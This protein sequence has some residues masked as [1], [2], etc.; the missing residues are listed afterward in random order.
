MKIGI[1]LLAVILA[2]VLIGTVAAT[3]LQQVY[4]PRECPGCG[5]EF[6]DN[7][8]LDDRNSTTNVLRHNQSESSTLNLT[9]IDGSTLGKQ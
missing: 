4:A 9:N 8:T 6:N 5:F 2:S 1:K 3:N 7:Q